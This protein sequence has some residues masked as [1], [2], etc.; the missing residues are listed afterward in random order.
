MHQVERL[1]EEVPE[2]SPQKAKSVVSTSCPSIPS[3]RSSP[4][5]SRGLAEG[6]ATPSTSSSHGEK[7]TSPTQM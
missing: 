6:T 4:G 2:A 5:G 7:L 3:I 1:S